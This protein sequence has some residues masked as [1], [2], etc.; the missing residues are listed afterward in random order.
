MSDENVGDGTLP[1]EI[2]ETSGTDLSPPPKRTKSSFQSLHLEALKTAK[3]MQ[4]E[5]LSLMDKLIDGN[6]NVLKAIENTSKLQ[7]QLCESIT[8]LIE[9]IKK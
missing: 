2:G 4:T 5:S 6:T 3:Q 7:L 8:K 1:E 9:V